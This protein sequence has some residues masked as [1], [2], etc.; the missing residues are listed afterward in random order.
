MAERVGFA[1]SNGQWVAGDVTDEQMDSIWR[2]FHG[3]SGGFVRVDEVGGM[4]IAI[5]LDHIVAIRYNRT[6]DAGQ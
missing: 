5:R 2:L 1:L 6:N 4:E 3:Q